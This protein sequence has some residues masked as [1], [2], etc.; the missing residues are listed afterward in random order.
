M[1]RLLSLLLIFG[2]LTPACTPLNAPVASPGGPARLVALQPGSQAWIVL[3]ETGQVRQQTRLDMP[4]GCEI[5]SAAGQPQHP[6]L[7]VQLICGNWPA[8]LALDTLG[9]QSRLL[10]VGDAPDSHLLGWDV[11]SASP[12]AF[13]KADSFGDTAIVR[14]YVE[15]NRYER[16]AGLP[17]YTYHMHSIPGQTVYAFTQGLGFGSELWLADGSLEQAGLLRQDA[18]ILGFATLSPDGSQVAYIDIADSTEAF[19]DGHLWVMESASGNSRQLAGAPAGTGN[20]LAWS[21]DSTAIAF[22]GA[23]G[24]SI[25]HFE[26]DELLATPGRM[27]GSPAWSPDGAWAIATL[28]AGDTMG[29]WL[30][31][32]STQQ[33][34]ALP[35]GE[36]LCCAAWVGAGP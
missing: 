36:G 20:G 18:A 17:F 7:L 25:Y 14:F 9:G 35:G 32:T 23:G 16:L 34:M 19:T 5:A 2:W 30:Y 26:T 11:N 8:V 29:L 4:P 6:W 13:L 28:A 15:E 33:F 3:G 24:F 1:K 27:L 31:E 10:L 21:P 22:Y 12:A